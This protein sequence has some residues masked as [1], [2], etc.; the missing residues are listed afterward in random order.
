M[1]SFTWNQDQSESKNNQDLTSNIPQR[2]KTLILG[3][4]ILKQID[5][6]RLNNRM[7]STVSVRCIPGATADVMKHHLNPNIWVGF[8]GVCFEVGGDKITHSPRPP[9]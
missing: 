4:S 8:L 6:W 5:S 3:D 1:H 9:V 2:K 7:K